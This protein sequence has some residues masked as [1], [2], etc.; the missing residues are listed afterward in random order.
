MFCYLL[1][2]QELNPHGITP[3]IFEPRPNTIRLHIS[4]AERF[5]NQPPGT[6]IQSKEILAI[7]CW[8]LSSFP[9][10]DE[11]R[12]IYTVP[13]LRVGIRYQS[14]LAAPQRWHS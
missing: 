13:V 14:A 10:S 11:Q 4:L 6:Y 2:E 8:L 7:C 9:S 3:G 1:Q 12:L 5:A